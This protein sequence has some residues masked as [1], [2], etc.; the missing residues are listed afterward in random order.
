MADFQR[1]AED[2]I[3][4]VASHIVLD[5]LRKTVVCKIGGSILEKVNP[6]FIEDI[7][8]LR[9]EGTRVVLVHGGG[10][11]VTKIA[12]KLGKPQRFV[13]S[14]LGVRSRYTDKETVQIYTMVMSGLLSKKIVQTL[15]SNG[16][17]AVSLTGLDGGLLIAYRRQRL[18]I[19]DENRNKVVIDGGYTGKITNVNTSLIDLLTEMSIVPVISPVATESEAWTILNVDSDRACSHIAAALKA[20]ASIYLT[21]TDGVILDK[22]L[23]AHFTSSEARSALRL[24]GSGMDKKVMS[25]VEAVEMGAKRSIIASGLKQ[26]PIQKALSGIGTVITRS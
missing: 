4:R 8:S 14:P 5:P 23:I 7:K 15:L 25:A 12:E 16:I 26:N 21:D 18:A 19:L 13:V 17:D 20:E 24:I 1:T 10:E 22:E 2:E 9:A 11:Q 6:S 3:P